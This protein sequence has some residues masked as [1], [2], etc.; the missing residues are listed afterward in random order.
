MEIK[1]VLGGKNRKLTKIC[2]N[3][4]RRIYDKHKAVAESWFDK[5]KGLI[6]YQ[7][8]NNLRIECGSVRMFVANIAHFGAFISSSN[9]HK[10]FS[11]YSKNALV[12][13]TFLSV[14]LIVTKLPG[15]AR[16]FSLSLSYC[17]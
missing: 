7:Q 10:L 16:I 15:V 2:S 8:F 14:I 1:I 12:C 17:L 3:P 11:F 9:C 6:K 13:L 5:V 4:K